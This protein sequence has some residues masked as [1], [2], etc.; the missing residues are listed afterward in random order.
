MGKILYVAST[1]SHISS[2]HIP[3]IDKLRSL[4]NQVMIMARGEGADFDVPFEKKLLSGKNKKCRAMIRRIL[5]EESF[6]LIILNTSLAAFHVRQAIPRGKRPRVVN[7]AHGYLFSKSSEGVK[8]RIKSALLL[9]AEKLQRRRTDAI[10]TMNREDLDL[11]VRH[12]LT[13]G[14]VENTLGMG[15]LRRSPE[16][17]REEI[18]R[19]LGI[20]NKFAMTFVGELSGRK[21]QSFLIEALPQLKADIPSCVLMLVGEGDKRVELSNLARELGVED[22]VI[23]AGRKSNVEDYIYAS[24]LYVSASRSEGLPF[25]IVE[26]LG[27]GATVI[28]SGVKGHTDILDDGSGITFP[29]GSR[30]AFCKEVLKVYRCETVVSEKAKDAAFLKYSFDNVFSK[31]FD[32]ICRVAD[33]TGE[34][35]LR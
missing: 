5:R 21:N 24:D 23:F 33:P 35:I 28:A 12:R 20:D 15:V 2:F 7:V 19:S 16:L 30:E 34:I 22:S 25:N 8:G 13:A 1:F 18:R 3:Y 4:G 26:A 31:T 10:I 27:C 17:P 6:D 29:P 9:F 11:A 14:P 32:A